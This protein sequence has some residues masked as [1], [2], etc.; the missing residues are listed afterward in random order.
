MTPLIPFP[1]CRGG[2]RYLEA[3]ERRIRALEVGDRLERR[4]AGTG[5]SKVRS[6]V[7]IHLVLHTQNDLVPHTKLCI[8][9][10]PFF[11]HEYKWQHRL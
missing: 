3:L 7:A 2:Q 11:T 5:S 8:R 9:H 1:R 10:E 6:I 4:A